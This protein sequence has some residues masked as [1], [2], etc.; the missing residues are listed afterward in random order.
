[1][2]KKR[3]YLLFQIYNIV[4]IWWLYINVN[5]N[6]A[7]TLLFVIALTNIA[8]SYMSEEIILQYKEMIDNMEIQNGIQK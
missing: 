4:L 1:M 6:F 7:F 2:K 5:S 8:S 3:I